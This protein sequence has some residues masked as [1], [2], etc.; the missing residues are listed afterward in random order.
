[1]VIVA[2]CA[3]Q[4]LHREGMALMEQGRAEE[5]LAKL[6]QASKADPENLSYRNAWLRNREQVANRLAAAAGGE[7]AAGRPDEAQA[8]YER[9]LRLDP[10]NSRARLGL[11]E[12]AQDKRHGAMVEEAR[13]LFQND[14]DA[15][16]AALKPVLLENPRHGEALLLQR[17]I[18]EQAA[19]VLMAEPTLRAKFRKPVT[20]QF[21]DANL[22]L[23]LEALSRTSGINVLLDKDVKPDIKTSIFVKDVSVEDAI[24]LILLQSQLERK[25]ISDNTVFIYP[26]TPAKLKDYQDLKIRSFHL[27]NADPKQMLTMIKTLLKTKDIFVHEKT[28]SLVMRDTPEAI[29]LAEKM[30]ADQDIADPEVM[31]EVEVLEISRSR[32]AEI[33]IN[34]PSQITFTA[35]GAAATPTVNE[36]RQLN[37]NNIVTS[38]AL[39]ATLN[40]LLQDGDTNLLASPRIRARNREKAKIMIGDRVPVITNAVTPV[41]TGTPVIT[42]SVQYL[43]VGLK[44]EVEPEVHMDNE[45][46]IKVN[47]EVSSIAKEVLNAVSGTLAY[48]VGTR[49]A[50]TV[51]RLKDGETQILAGLINDEDRNTASKVPGIGDLPIVG[52]LFSSH[53]DNGSKTEIVLSITPRVIG[54]SRR[55]D[56]REVEYWSGTESSLRSNPL[57]LKPLGAVAVSSTGSG[58]PVARARPVPGE[59]AVAAQPLAF[60]WQGPKQAR[61]GERI[62]IAL[63]TQ[64]QQD[65]GGLGLLVG[66]DPAVLKAT[67]VAPGDWMQTDGAPSNFTRTI[68]QASGQIL[69][70]MKGA[71]GGEDGSV[72]MLTFEVTAATPQTPVTASRISLSGTGGEPLAAM[73]P[74]PHFIAVTQ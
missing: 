33:G 55:P 41:T 19:R 34:Y 59:T 17:Q 31:L 57:A 5:G 3:G 32:L 23:V 9:I 60:S 43:D 68:D 1:A 42:G 28:N 65:A 21:R 51:L 64:A 47:M 63:N 38:P 12:L 61:V 70:D 45:V 58:A 74:A 6:E 49:N 25:T 14:A 71:P 11:E 7:R 18:D 48:Q 39:S 72:V 15:A 30:V 56:A 54:A 73:P 50:S 2:G 24:D 35:R 36:L 37:G 16:R 29:R 44:L 52:R 8:I 4:R 46:S 69:V 10:D 62:T 26:N 40:L 67:D 13:G 20:L 53:R 27:T 22:K 66:Y